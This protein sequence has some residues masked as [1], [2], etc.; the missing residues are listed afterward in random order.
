MAAAQ[1]LYRQ[2]GFR[3]IPKYAD[4]PAGA[5]YGVLLPKQL[6]EQMHLAE[7]DTLAIAQ[8]PD[9]IQLSPYGPNFERAM[10]AF[11]GVRKRYR[12]AFRKLAK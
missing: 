5:V 4:N 7:G 8:T 10:Q 12:N 3:E 1:A 2:F 6:L 11:V 9:G